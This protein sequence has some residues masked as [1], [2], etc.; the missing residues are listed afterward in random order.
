MDLHALIPFL[1][2]HGVS[3]FKNQDLEVEFHIPLTSNPS[4]EPDKVVEMPEPS[5]MPPDLRADD[6][7]NEDKVINWSAPPG[8][9]TDL[10]PPMP[11]TGETALDN[12]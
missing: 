6:L 11:L 1:K 2:Q 4:P 3:W 9:E 10:E 8:P 12:Q 7:F 5:N